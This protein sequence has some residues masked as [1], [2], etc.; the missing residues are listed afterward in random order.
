[1]VRPQ[2]K[3]HHVSVARFP[4]GKRRVA[5]AASTAL[6]A[7]SAALL[8]TAPAA[9]AA[10]V[11]VQILG[12]NDFHGRLLRNVSPP[13]NEAGAAQ[14]GGGYADLNDRVM[15]PGHAEGGAKWVYL[16]SN[17]RKKS[18][19]SYALRSVTPDAANNHNGANA[20]DGGTWMAETPGGA[21]VGF[22]GAV[23]EELPSLVS[24]G[25]IV[26]VKVTKTWT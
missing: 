17:V 26:D 11:E 8:A 7:S 15:A 10:T 5:A 6:I 12:T 24:P 2:R 18:D 1:M 4:G 16:A 21:K 20:S 19:N 13:A 25:G 22:V 9:H 3:A 23:T 14:F